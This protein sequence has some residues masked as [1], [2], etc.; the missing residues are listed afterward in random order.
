MSSM[1]DT[2]HGKTSHDTT[3]KGVSIDFTPLVYPKYL[4]PR[5]ATTLISSGRRSVTSLGGDF[6]GANA[7]QSE[8]D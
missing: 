5:A 6:R 7:G 4:S 8:M 2:H 1:I 3:T